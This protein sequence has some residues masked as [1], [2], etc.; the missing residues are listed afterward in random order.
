MGKICL[1]VCESRC[2]PRADADE[3]FLQRRVLLE[4]FRTRS[5]PSY[6]AV[7]L[8]LVLVMRVSRVRVRVP[9]TYV[10]IDSKSSPGPDK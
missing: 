9:T 10:A 3:E 2:G 5:V 8:P 1:G 4:V 7:A 6:V